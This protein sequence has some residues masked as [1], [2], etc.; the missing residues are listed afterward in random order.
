LM[1]L[2]L[3]EEDA[4][5]TTTLCADALACLQNLACCPDNHQPMFYFPGLMNVLVKVLSDPAAVIEFKIRVLG[6]LVNLLQNSNIR[7]PTFRFPG[8]IPALLLVVVTPAATNEMKRIALECLSRLADCEEN[9]GPIILFP[10]FVKSL[11]RITRAPSATDFEKETAMGCVLAL[12][13]CEPCAE[14]MCSFVGMMEL[15]IK[16]LDDP[17]ATAEMKSCALGC[18]INFSINVV[19]RMALMAHPGLVPLVIKIAQDPA[20]LDELKMGVFGFLQNL[21]RS[22]SNAGELFL[23][24][25]FLHLV[26]TTITQRTE[27]PN[28]TLRASYVMFDLSCSSLIACKVIQAK[29]KV[30]VPTLVRIQ[31]GTFLIDTILLINLLGPKKHKKFI[32]DLKLLTKIGQELLVKAFK[33]EDWELSHVLL[34]LSF[35]TVQRANR[36]L[37]WGQVPEFPTN[38]FRALELATVDHERK[39]PVAAGFAF[40]VLIQFVLDDEFK[41]DLRGKLDVFKLCADTIATRNGEA[42]VEVHQ[43]CTGLIQMLEMN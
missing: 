26:F 40:A 31:N 11:L 29:C 17:V 10:N 18:L 7:V 42:W 28:L 23:Y 33:Q 41:A 24:P 35:L 25:G 1:P 8:L 38:L 15:M 4:K 34:P 5:G 12:S 21:S 3:G 37:L 43:Q 32:V 13:L 27:L 22:P 14:R 9:Q 36:T 16:L 39:E 30:L 20:V 2:L 6:C 19:N